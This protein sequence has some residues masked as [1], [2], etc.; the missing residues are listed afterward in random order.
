M[1]R[2]N[3]NFERRSII[4]PN[5]EHGSADG[6]RYAELY[7]D[8]QI[9]CSELDE[10]DVRP[11]NVIPNRVDDAAF[12]R[13]VTAPINQAAFLAGRP[14]DVAHVIRP[15]GA[16]GHDVKTASMLV[17]R[18]GSWPGRTQQPPPWGR[19]RGDQLLRP[20]NE[21]SRILS[22]CRI[23]PPPSVRTLDASRGPQLADRGKRRCQRSTTGG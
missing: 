2:S 16:E 3:I 10:H 19:Q 14:C 1:L 18:V 7:H 13:L 8:V 12:F 21:S 23:E 11:A 15:I 17:V 22:L 5:G 9:C 6:M 20:G 4:P